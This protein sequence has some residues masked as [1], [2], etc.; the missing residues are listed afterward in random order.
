MTSSRFPGKVL[1]DLHGKPMI[2]RQLA[3]LARLTQIERLVVATSVDASDDRLVELVSSL[4]VEVF[5][6]DLNDVLGRF[7]AVA[8]RWNPEVIVRLTADCP[9]ASPTVIDRVISDFCATDVDYASNTLNPSFPDGLDV[10]V[11]KTSALSWMNENSTD[12]DEREHVT[13]GV[14]R[15]PEVFKL[16]SVRG[17]ADHSDLRWTVDEQDDL[18]FVRWVYS[19]LYDLNPEFEYQ[20]IL[21]LISRHPGKSRTS[22]DAIRN[23]ALIGLDTGAMD[24]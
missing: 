3:R 18:D 24:A 12:A 1:A 21:D 14:Y 10:E 20:D 15:R 6:G 7:V 8:D 19:E 17:D 5:R 9:L 23:A 4:G 16:L 13:L 2:A 11:V 22:A